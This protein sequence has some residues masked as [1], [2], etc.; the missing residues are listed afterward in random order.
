MGGRGIQHILFAASED[1]TLPAGSTQRVTRNVDGA[2]MGI[3]LYLVGSEDI[4]SQATQVADR[5]AI[6]ACQVHSHRTATLAWPV[7]Y[8]ACQSVTRRVTTNMA[9]CMG[10]VL[11]VRDHFSR[12]LGT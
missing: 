9:Y 12:N 11:F 4:L 3:R 7:Y 6:S 8:I 10:Y 1:A 5:F 2:L